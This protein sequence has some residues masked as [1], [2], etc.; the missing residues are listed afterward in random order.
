MTVIAQTNYFQRMDNSLIY[1]TIYYTLNN[2]AFFGIGL[3]AMHRNKLQIS[4]IERETRVHL[5]GKNCFDESN[6]N[7]Y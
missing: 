1:T 7:T 3:L 2:L 4:T 6:N 5:G